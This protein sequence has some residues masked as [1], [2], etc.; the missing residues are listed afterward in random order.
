MSGIEKTGDA[1][2]TF[3]HSSVKRLLTD[4]KEVYTNPLESDGIYYKHDENDFNYGYALIIGPKDTIYENGYFFYK[5]EFPHDY[6]HTP[7]KVIYHTNDGYVRFHPNFYRNGKVCLS[8]LNT[9]RGEGWTSCQSIRSIL[10]I[11][12]SLLSNDPLLNEPGVTKKH[13]DFEKYNMI[14]EY[15]TLSVAIT[16]MLDDQAGI[17]PSP[18]FDMF[19]STVTSHFLD[20]YRVN[21]SKI[22][23][24][25][26]K[27]CMD[28]IK[29][30]LY[31]LEIKI[32]YRTLEEAIKKIYKLV[33]GKHSEGSNKK[34]LDKQNKK[35]K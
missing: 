11:L 2:K 10:L 17:Y 4:V 24:L 25:C 14:I 30:D 28:T 31:N 18:H 5:L 9:W 27:R 1:R 23:E 19:K 13:P 33:N 34:S 7:P 8:I 32:N 12:C 21:L 22:H 20:N 6:P 15:K 29:T 26:S 3:A 35:L 16:G